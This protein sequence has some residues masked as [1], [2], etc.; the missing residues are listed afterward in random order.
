[1]EGT[2]CV[3][4]FSSQVVLAG[5]GTTTRNSFDWPDDGMTY[6]VAWPFTPPWIEWSLGGIAQ[7]GLLVPSPQDNQI[8]TYTSPKMELAPGNYTLFVTFGSTN[9]NAALYPFHA[10]SFVPGF[11]GTLSSFAWTLNFAVITD[12]RIDCPCM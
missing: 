7:D 1:M 2:P 4:Q 9:G 8:P 5:T 6:S 3:Y 12:A 10:F 11:G